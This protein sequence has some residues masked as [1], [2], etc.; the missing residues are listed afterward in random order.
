MTIILILAAFGGG[1]FGS[2]IGGTIAFIFTGIL[3]LLGF[4]ILLTT[5]DSMI[6]DKIAFGPFFGPQV[7]F[8]G[9]VAAA[10]YAGRKNKMAGSDVMSPL[11]VTKD[12]G[13][14]V[15]GGIFGVVGYVMNY[16][17]STKGFGIDT[18]ALTVVILGIVT[19]LLIGGSS[20]I[21]QYVG[22]EKWTNGLKTE[23]PF[24][25]IWALGL[26]LIVGF[27]VIETGL[28]N[29][30]WAI[31]AVSLIFLFTTVKAFPVSHH[32]T[33]VAGYAAIAFNS[34]YMAALFGVI[35]VLLGEFF[36]RTTNTKVKSHL[37]MPAVVIA[38]CSLVILTF[39]Q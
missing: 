30:G 11:F 15:V 21:S 12:A 37:D 23:L 14:L 35:A 3:A 1:V 34:I 7:A 10:A 17:L 8:V 38:S 20:L 4:A 27:A 13:S 31:S 26:S 22:N 2:L 39:F 6:L 5:G 24:N 32:V 28:A 9:A 19:R 29:I 25:V 16:F 33:M 36:Q 18:I